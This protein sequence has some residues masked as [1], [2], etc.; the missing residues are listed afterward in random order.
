MMIDFTL[1]YDSLPAL[2]SGAWVTLQI[3]TLGCF[4]GLSLGILLGF[5]ESSKKWFVR[6]PVT[7]Y[8]AIIR[9]T[10]LIIQLSF[11][12]LILPELG[13]TLATFWAATFAIGINSSAYISQIIR[14]GIASVNKGQ[15]E[16]ARTLGLSPFDIT[17]YIVLPQAIAVVLPALGNELIT[18]IKESSLASTVGIME[19]TKQ[20][21]AIRT[22]T[23]DVITVFFGVAV[24][25]LLMTT[26][27]S[28][29]VSWLEK[30]M[31]RHANR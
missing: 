12:I 16:A 15:I 24:L 7:I 19:L 31:N 17:W 11:A 1:L 6:L 9:G 22:K 4:L 23:F 27:L 13:I 2:L 25:Y 18:L 21:N 10:P 8:A 3:A 28:L 29:A 5:M 20:G 26:T 14:S 30:R